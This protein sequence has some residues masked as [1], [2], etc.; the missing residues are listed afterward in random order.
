MENKNL[1]VSYMICTWNRRE[2]LQWHLR[3]LSMQTWDKPFE[4][5]VCVDGSTDGTQKMLRFWDANEQFQRAKQRGYNSKFFLKWYDTGNVDRATPAVARNCGIRHASGELLIMVDDDCLPNNN[6]I[7]AYASKFDPREIQ[8]GYR[9]SQRAYLD[10]ELPVPIEEGKMQSYFQEWESGRF[11][12]GHFTTGNAAMS[13]EAARIKAK[14]GS[15]GFDERFEKYGW[16]DVELADR[17][18]KLGYKFVWNPDAVIWHMNPSATNQRPREQKL[19]EK[20]EGRALY[21]QIRN[22]PMP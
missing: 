22:E 8:V 17:L 18:D 13:I 2:T 1:L 7:A 9:S 3:R 20:E 14:D 16:E 11:R 19:K 12:K 15:V 6:L 4:V 5:I 10:K 21:D